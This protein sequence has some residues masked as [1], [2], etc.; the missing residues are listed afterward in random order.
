[1]CVCAVG[2]GVYVLLC[3]P[4]LAATWFGTSSQIALPITCDIL[5]AF[6]CRAQQ[7]CCCYCSQMVESWRVCT[8]LL[9]LTLSLCYSSQHLGHMCHTM[10]ALHTWMI[11]YL[12]TAAWA[13]GIT[14]AAAVGSVPEHLICMMNLCIKTPTCHAACIG[15]F[16]FGVSGR[17]R[18]AAR[19]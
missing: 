5:L 6:V 3:R 16:L 17:D 13:G 9:L 11:H 7:M 1:M 12:P 14:T 2:V 15:L 18:L 8:T 10:S 19:G 4:I